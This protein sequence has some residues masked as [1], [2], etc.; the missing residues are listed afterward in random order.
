ML[1]ATD[2]HGWRPAHLHVAVSAPGFE[3]LTSHLFDRS[4]PYL[5]SD[6]VF[7]VTPSLVCAFVEHTGRDQT[8][9][10]LGLE[11]P[12]CIVDFD[13]ALTPSPAS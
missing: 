6:A 13:F 7:A 3:P 4:D 5:E 1:R 2:R 11:P 9:E 8:A 10:R 12:F